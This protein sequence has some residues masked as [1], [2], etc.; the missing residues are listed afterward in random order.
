M[1]FLACSGEE[2]LMCE[3]GLVCVFVIV[4]SVCRESPVSS[5]TFR[6][7]FGL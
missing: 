4:G 5:A 3:M 6:A 1:Y 2:G 7:F